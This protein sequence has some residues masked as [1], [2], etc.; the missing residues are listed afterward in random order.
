LKLENSIKSLEEGTKIAYEIKAG[1]FF[2]NGLEGLAIAN[3]E[4]KNYK[5]AAYYSLRFNTVSDSLQSTSIEKQISELSAKY[6]S[7]KKD[8]E[9]KMQDQELKHKSEQ[10]AKQKTLTI[11][12]TVALVMSLVAIIFVYRSYRSNKKN[13][14]A[15]EEKNHLIEEKNREIMDSINYAKLIQQSLLASKEMLD[16][17][18]ESYFILY[19]PKDV[20][21]G[22]FYW[23]SESENGFLIACVDC[24]GH[25]VPGAFMSLIGKENLDKAV[26]KSSK[27]GLI[28][29]DLNNSVKKS[30]NQSESN[31]SKDGMDAAICH[32]EKQDTKVQITYSG[33]NRP[34][35]I[36]RKDNSFEEIKA[37]KQAIGGF[38]AFD[39]DFEEHIV[40][41]EKGDTIFM[42][43]DGFAD[44]FGST[45]NKKITTKRFK[46]LLCKVS[47]ET[48]S[49]QQ[50]KLEGFF[51]DWQGKQEQLDDVLVIGIRV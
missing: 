25:G 38:T 30:L 19:K 44:Q 48:F 41:L 40:H 16:R 27:P 14:K 5:N 50:T 35:Y 23:A 18:L 47:T 17:N 31:S 24:T 33:A 2:K 11:A 21:S 46:D 20:V 34:L 9:L 36:V 7:T 32:F 28:L 22:D 13:A 29:R 37:T 51:E 6:E 45:K 4:A 8:A 1:N 10:N 42:T 3:Y 12:S 49:N 26:S 39:Q 15:L 43:T